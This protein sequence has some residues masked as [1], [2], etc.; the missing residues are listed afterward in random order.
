MN[1]EERNPIERKGVNSSF[2]TGLLA[3]ILIA[4]VISAVTLFVKRMNLTDRVV[5]NRTITAK[6]DLAED[7]IVS[8][9]TMQKMQ[10]IQNTVKGYYLDETDTQTLENGIYH[11]M[12]DAIGDP[13]STYYSK[14][15]LEEMKL[16]TEGIYYGIGAYISFDVNTKMGRISKVIDDTPA[17]AAGIKAGDYIYKV[18]DEYVKGQSLEFVVSKIKGAEG[19]TVKISML[20]ENEK[21]PIEFQVVREKIESPTVVHRTLEAGISYIQITEFD[22]VTTNQFS[23]AYQEEK[24]KGMK[25]LILDLR[26]NLGGNLATVTDIARQMLPKGLIV[27]TE[28]KEGKREEYSCDGSHEI[29]VPLVVLVNGNSASASEILAGAIKD[30]EIGTLL[31]TTTF[32][33]GIVQRIITLSDGSAVKLTVSKYYTPNGICIHKVGIS[34]DVELE[35][36]M[37]NF[38]KN[39][40]DNQLDAALKLVKEKIN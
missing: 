28:D 21:N 38:I 11:G 19:T 26:D 15:E 18:D 37:E 9:E 14:D 27:Y 25:G 22:E 17:E 29:D 10:L 8:S 2:L 6:E 20:R 7:S 30:Y 39:G 4:V 33:K 32:G 3:G 1:Q 12:V 16:K 24:E 34:P 36:D 35:L 13:Y 23:A 5:S 40:T 31:G